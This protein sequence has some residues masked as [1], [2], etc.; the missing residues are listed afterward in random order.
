MKKILFIVVLTFS[1]LILF[2]YLN[3]NYSLSEQDIPLYS[4]PDGKVRIDFTNESSE[5]IRSIQMIG[6]AFRKVQHLEKKERRT[7]LFQ[8]KGEGTISY[9]LEFVSGR[10][11]KAT[12]YIE[13][14]YFIREFIFDTLIKTKY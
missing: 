10:K 5:E 6:A 8:H 2:L 11:L 9:E 13:R 3:K 4:V 7:V 1:C 14:G 12:H